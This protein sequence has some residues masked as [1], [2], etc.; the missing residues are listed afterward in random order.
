[1]ERVLADAGIMPEDRPTVLAVSEA[2]I[3][4]T[5][6]DECSFATVAESPTLTMKVRGLG[7]EM[8]ARKV[9]GAVA[10]C[11][12]V[13]DAVV[14][15]PRVGVDAPLE[16]H[17]SVLKRGK[18]GIARYEPKKIERTFFKDRFARAIGGGGILSPRAINLADAI[19]AETLTYAE[20]ELSLGLW[21]PGPERCSL[22]F[23]GFRECSLSFVERLF[24]LYGHR[25]EDVVFESSGIVRSATIFADA[26]GSYAPFPARAEAEPKE[27]DGRGSKKKARLF[28]GER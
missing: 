26:I 5:S 1:M 14:L 28:G 17:V 6:C 2:L 15:F 3:A 22:R 23:S 19:V 18:K 25:I 12:G 8:S 11:Q 21:S 4:V 20:P 10:K 24:E 13:S 7:I 16:L 27:R 9:L